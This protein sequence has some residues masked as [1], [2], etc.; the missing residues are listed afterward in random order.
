MLDRE[1]D[2]IL[3]KALSPDPEGRYA[4]CVEFLEALMS[5]KDRH[6]T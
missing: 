2:D 5:Y 3:L 1:M 6:A 4:T